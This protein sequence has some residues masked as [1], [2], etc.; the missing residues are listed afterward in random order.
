MG[1]PFSF[2]I[3][4]FRTSTFQIY[5]FSASFFSRFCFH[6][7]CVTINCARKMA[8]N[9]EQIHPYPG[10]RY[11]RSEI[12]SDILLGKH[13][14]PATFHSYNDSAVNK[15]RSYLRFACPSK[16]RSHPAAGQTSWTFGFVTPAAIFGTCIP[17]CECQ[18]SGQMARLIRR[19]K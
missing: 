15:I 12:L 9:A 1:A 19:D 17:N 3:F 2:F 11:F 4:L 16:R 18:T 14:L 10:V 8:C 13:P 6:F 5:T 7:F